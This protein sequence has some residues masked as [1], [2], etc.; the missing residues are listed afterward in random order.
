MVNLGPGDLPSEPDIMPGKYLK[1]RISDNGHGMDHMVMERIFDPFFTTKDLGSGT[2]LGLSVAHGIIKS[3]GGYINVYS[4]PGKGTTFNVYMPQIKPY[5]EEPKLESAKQLQMG[6]ERI[7]LVDDE[8][9]I[10]DMERQMGVHNE[11]YY[12]R[13]A[14]DG[15]PAGVG[16]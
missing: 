7:L 4:E 11:T 14:G 12:L 16:A 1:L 6:K 3:Y 5:A 13:Q 15:N 9:Q 8:D 10:V 2:G